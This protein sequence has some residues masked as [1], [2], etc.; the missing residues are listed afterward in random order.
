MDASQRHSYLLRSR[1]SQKSKAGTIGEFQ[2]GTSHAD[3]EPSMIDLDQ[4]Q[5]H[6]SSL[7]DGYLKQQASLRNQ[8]VRKISNRDTDTSQVLVKVK[9]GNHEEYLTKSQL[10]NFVF[11]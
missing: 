9:V 5:D 3:F 4:S 7:L 1:R 6:E 10:E 8:E 11:E 2:D